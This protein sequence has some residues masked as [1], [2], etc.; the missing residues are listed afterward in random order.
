MHGILHMEQ[1]F[2]GEYSS[3]SF[4]VRPLLIQAGL[5]FMFCCFLFFFSNSP[6]MLLHSPNPLLLFSHKHSD[7]SLSRQPPHR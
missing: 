3:L 1:N 5:L 4:L 7:C 2:K 6:Q